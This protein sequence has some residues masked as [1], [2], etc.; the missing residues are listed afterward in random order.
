MILD[1]Y[2]S[3]II[4]GNVIMIQNCPSPPEIRE[5]FRHKCCTGITLLVLWVDNS[6]PRNDTSSSLVDKKSESRLYRTH[7]FYPE[8]GLFEAVTTEEMDLQSGLDRLEVNGTA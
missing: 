7:V 3:L 8:P 2:I 5:A 1:I 4:C 6:D